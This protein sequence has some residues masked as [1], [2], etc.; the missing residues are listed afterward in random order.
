MSCEDHARLPVPVHD[1]VPAKTEREKSAELSNNTTK[2]GRKR[3]ILVE[4]QCY[5]F[6][7]SRQRA[8]KNIIF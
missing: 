1:R 5:Q 7:D 6:Q 8:M 2:T 3:S 4:R